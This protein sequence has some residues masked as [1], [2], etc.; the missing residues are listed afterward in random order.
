MGPM[1]AAREFALR[2]EPRDCSRDAGGGHP[3]VR[4]PGPDR[5]RPW[6][7]PR[8]AAGAHR[9]GSAHR[10]SGP[11]GADAA[12]DPQQRRSC[13]LLGRHAI[14]F[15]E[16]MQLLFMRSERL[17]RHTNGMRFTALDAAGA[18][19][20]EEEYYSLGGGFIVRGED[21]GGPGPAA[22]PPYPF[23]SGAELLALCREHGLEIFELMLANERPGA[24]RG[25]SASSCWRSGTS[26]RR[27]WPRLSPKRE[28]CRIE[29]AAPRALS[30]SPPPTDRTRMNCLRKNSRRGPER[31]R[32]RGWLSCRRSPS[33]SRTGS[34]IV[35]R[36]TSPCSFRPNQ[37]STENLLSPPGSDLTQ[38]FRQ[39]S[40]QEPPIQTRLRVKKP[41]SNRPPFDAARPPQ[42]KP[43]MSRLIVRS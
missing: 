34:G 4:F 26:C 38:P 1:R 24:R 16:P 19:L 40:P 8:G 20:A 11:H 21:A 15:D 37:G 39:R 36:R 25:R 18:R 12:A 43:P 13:V 22:A 17:P 41:S 2:L 3:P 6:Y 32:K 23:T 31:R 33:R 10:G 42:T 14:A 28:C 30:R 35:F 5:Q 9:R 27:A 29:G 7:G